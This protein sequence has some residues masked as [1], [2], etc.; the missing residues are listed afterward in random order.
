MCKSF[1]KFYSIGWKLR[2]SKIWRKLAL[3]PISTFWPMF[4]S[5]LIG[6]WESCFFLFFF[7]SKLFNYNRY[8]AYRIPLTVNLA[9]YSDACLVRMFDSRSARTS[10]H[11]VLSVQIANSSTS[12]GCHNF[13]SSMLQRQ[14]AITR[15]ISGKARATNGGCLHMCTTKLWKEQEI[16]TER[17]MCWQ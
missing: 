12:C 15:K 1:A 14:A 17:T 4:T 8:A 6:Y 2:I 9:I 5:K 11:K 7:P 16:T 10:L 13:T 3:W